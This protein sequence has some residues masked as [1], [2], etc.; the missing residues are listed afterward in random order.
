MIDEI[1]REVDKVCGRPLVSCADILAVAARDSVVAVRVTVYP[2]NYILIF[3]NFSLLILLQ[4]KK[5]DY[6]ILQNT[7]SNLFVW[8]K[9]LST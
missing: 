1:K 4:I 5:D 3:F 6:F 2:N 8:K 7:P 9:S